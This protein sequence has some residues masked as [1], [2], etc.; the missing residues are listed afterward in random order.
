MHR[1]RYSSPRAC[2]HVHIASWSPTHDSGTFHLPPTQRPPKTNQNIY[3]PNCCTI[4][5]IPARMTNLNGRV[6]GIEHHESRKWI[7]TYKS[8]HTHPFSN[9]SISILFLHTDKKQ[10]GHK[11]ALKQY[12]RFQVTCSPPLF[13]FRPHL[14]LHFPLKHVACNTGCCVCSTADLHVLTLLDLRCI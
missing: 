11:H 7:Q 12:T 1:T 6:N 8:Q 14:R 9:S 10:R 2:A 13:I 5:C 4:F 3:S